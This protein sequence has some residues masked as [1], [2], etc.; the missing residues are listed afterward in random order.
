MRSSEEGSIRVKAIA[1]V[2]LITFGVYLGFRFLLPLVLPFIIAYFLAWIIRPITEFLFR[3]MKIPRLIGGTFTLLVLVAATGAG[4]CYLVNILLKQAIAFIKNIPV[5]LDII[6]DKLDASCLACDKLLGF[7]HGTL[8]AIV[9]EN[10]INTVN[11]VKSNIM[12]NL[13]QRTLSF[14]IFLI[15]ALGVI[16]IVLIATVL[17]VNDLPKFKKRYEGNDLYRDF[18]KVSQ[19]LAEAGIAYLRSQFIILVIVA[20][21]CVLG[22]TLIKSDYALLLGISIAIMDALPI[23]GSGIVFIPW[24]IIM[25]VNGNI[26]AAAILITT[27]LICQIAREVLEPKLIGNQ[28]G[29]KPLFTLISMYVGFQLFSI[30]GFILGPIGLVVIITIWKVLNEKSRNSYEAKH[31]SYSDEEGD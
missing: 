8:R 16:L 10:I 1:K 25:L 11:R 5:Y 21:F 3:R 4:L 2:A 31:Y 29:I 19:K 22:L 9:D 12:P 6:A 15:A 24:S 23:L 27:Y 20:F 18:H 14:S 30:A 17:I 28:I 7:N 26:Y 13:T